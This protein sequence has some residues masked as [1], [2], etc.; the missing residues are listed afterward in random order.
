MRLPLKHCLCV[1]CAVLLSVV[2]LSSE[3]DFGGVVTLWAG[4]WLRLCLAWNVA[5][6]A[7]RDE[8]PDQ[9]TFPTKKVVW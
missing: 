2:V 1:L 6:Q 5:K 4:K 8:K 7:S 3:Q 9:R